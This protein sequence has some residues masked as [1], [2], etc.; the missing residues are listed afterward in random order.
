M[1]TGTRPSSPAEGR[2]TVEGYATDII[3]DL[4]IDWVE[5]LDGDD[6]WCVLVYHKAPHRP[7]EPK[8]E[9]RAMFAD[10]VPLPDTFWDDM[11]TR[12]ASARRVAMRVADHL[13]EEDLKEAPPAGLGYDELAVWKYQRYMQDYLAC[14]ESVDEN[15]G[16]VV[17]WLRDRGDFD[18]TLLMYSS[19]QGFFLGDHGWF[20]KRL[21]Y[22]ESLR[23]PLVLSYPRQ[24]AAG[25]AYDGIVTN[26]DMAQT[27]LDAA[28]V[29]HHPR[30][31]GE[32]C[33]PDLVGERD[34]R[35][36]EG[37][38]YRYWE[39][40]DLIHKAPAHY[41]YRTDRYKLIYFYNDGFVLPFT[42]FFTYPPEWELYDL[43]ADP[44][45]LRNVY[46]DPA[47]AAIRDELTAAMW[48][49]QARLG[50]A[51]HPSQ[52][53]PD[54]CD[55]VVVAAP[56]ELPPLSVAP[57]ARHGLTRFGAPPSASATVPPMNDV[58]AVNLALLVFRCGIGAVM[59]AHGINHIWNGGKLVI[60]GTAGWFESMGMRPPLVQ[61]WLASITEIAAGAAPRRRL[62][63]T[64]RRRRCRRGD[65]RRLGDQPS[66]Q[67]LLHL[68]PRRGL[69]VRDDARPVRDADRYGRPG[70]VVARPRPRPH[71]RPHG[72]DKASRSRP[73]VA[74]S[75]LSRCSR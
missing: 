2:R 42:G 24:L 36:V 25:R 33:W 14:V 20:D 73:V 17:D 40:D 58:D 59:L 60:D 38:Y 64:A 74:C 72:L 15:V 7:W 26:V 10:P 68:P 5:S 37:M 61:A 45:E 70:G 56:V 62:A 8:D 23:M 67:R 13:S 41:G 32:S 21:M 44:A 12:S 11:S 39:H 16:R 65:V 18:D 66:R 49:E 34:T 27:I 28:G 48:R 53:V 3:T 9:H 29:D 46:D 55:D 4:A 51:P 6:P 71:R 57:P 52:P 30:M 69:G 1:T 63:R 75:G 54:G 47:Y 22:E 35:P 31:Q 43:E 19:D 50:D